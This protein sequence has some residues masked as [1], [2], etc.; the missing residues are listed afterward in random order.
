[1][2]VEPEQ[3]ANLLLPLDREANAWVRRITSGHATTD[4]ALALRHWCARSP[5]HAAAFSAASQFWEAFGSAGQSLITD[6]RAA[7]ARSRSRGIGRRA[8]VGGALAA[9]AAGVLLVRPPL[10]LWP[11]FS[12]LKADFR[13][14]AGEQRQIAGADGLSIAMNARTSISITDGDV[15]LIAGEAS[16]VT[17]D[18]RTKRFNVVAG[19]GK[20]SALNARFDIR[21]AGSVIRV[22]CLADEIEVDHLGRTIVLGSRQQVSYSTDAIEKVVSIDPDVVSAWQRGWMIFTMTP[23]SDVID[24]LNRYR[25]GRII[26]INASLANSPVSAQFKIDRPDDALAQIELGFGVRRRT[27]PGGLILLS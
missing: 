5:A 26:L 4:D 6:E 16:F 3:D 1:M 9:S 25:S 20:T 17:H 15:E 8:F 11:S 2:T 10:D 7:D 18:D 22:T 27:L 14:G 19:G 21:H 13:T 12:E 23:L 24:E